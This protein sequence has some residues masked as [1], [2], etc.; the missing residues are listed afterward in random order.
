MS[1]SIEEKE[2][3]IFPRWRPF[4]ATSH[5]GEL[6]SPSESFSNDTSELDISLAKGIL[7]WNGD[8]SLWKSL[9]LLGSAIVAGR[10][11]EF[12]ALVAQVRDSPFAPRVAKQVLAKAINPLPQ[13][14][15]LPA[16]QQIPNLAAQRE[17]HT[18]RI[19]LRESP[20]DPIEW[21][22]LARA[23]TIAGSNPK[24]L[25]A[26][27]AA[28]QLAP[29]NRFV[30]RSAARFL[31]HVGARGRAYD[32]LTSAPGLKRD[33][34]LMASQIAIG[35]SIGK[36]PILFRAARSI[37]EGDIHPSDLTELASALGTLESESGNHKNARKFLRQALIN[38]NENSVAQVRWLNR[39]HLGNVVDESRVNPPL[40]HEANAWSSF[41]AADFQ[42][43]CDEALSWL[44]DQ[45]FA[46]APAVLSSYILADVIGD[47]KTG[48]D[49]TS[50]ALRSNPHDLSLLNNLAV[51]Q[52][53][54][55]ELKAAEITIKQIDD[56][57]SDRRDDAVITATKGML[58]FRKGDVEQGR[59]SYLKAIRLATEGG[60]KTTAARAAVH[61]AIEEYIA[62]TPMRALAMER[63]KAFSGEENVLEITG[64]MGRLK[65]LT[66]GQSS[67]RN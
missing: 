44:R 53:E 67:G 31:I 13:Q 18:R 22:E 21:V 41:Y 46:S 63:L 14:L 16:I 27:R 3:H 55:G 60:V 28:L 57:E 19:T 2:R 66:T 1:A 34:W 36:K 43:A 35:S 48:S 20:R 33:P 62:V 25:R 8:P 49:I 4:E 45:P 56:A 39:F 54:E 17:V 58:Y 15:D 32:L 40:L 38:P 50:A 42:R 52:I 65:Q 10:V 26:I 9:D 23:Y 24:A 59:T 5:L 61:L 47:F 37:A 12:S 7:A 51:C 29:S 11:Q 30:L 6:S 64:L